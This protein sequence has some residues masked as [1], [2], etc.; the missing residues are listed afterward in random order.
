VDNST[1]Q[2]LDSIDD[3][4]AYEKWY[5]GHYHTSKLIDKLLFMFEDIR[6]LR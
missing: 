3:K 5:C 6:E 4:L 2:W 1:E